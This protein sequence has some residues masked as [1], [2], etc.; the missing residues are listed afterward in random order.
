MKRHAALVPLSHDHQH[1]LAAALGLRRATETSAPDARRDFLAFW[2]TEGQAHFQIEETVLL[3]A[4]ADV[5]APD[6]EAIRR[7]LS[8]H[9]EIRSRSQQI[10]GEERPP[11]DDLHG[12][13]G[14]VEQHIRFEE[15]ELFPLI[16]TLLDEAELRA[17]ANEIE[18]AEGGA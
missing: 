4:V 14:L 13:G 18:I 9:A 12:L 6:H 11:L 16:E 1:G 8:D 7:V 2:Q 17:L 5:L 15:R 10:E 3:P